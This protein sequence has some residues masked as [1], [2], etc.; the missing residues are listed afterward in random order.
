MAD[1]RPAAERLYKAMKG[2]GTDEATLID[3]AASHTAD[4]RLAIAEAFAGLYGDTL[5][6]WLKKELSGHLEKL[7]VQL[8]KGRYQ[9]WAQYLDD[10]VRGAGTDEKLLIEMIFLMSDQD[11]Q[12]VE[13]EYRKLFNKD[14]T[15]TIEGDI[16]IGHWAKLIRAWL[17]AKNDAPA[18][19]EK[20]ADDLWAAAK[21]AG[22]DEQVF[23]QVLANC[24]PDVYHQACDAF[25]RKYRKDVAEVI[26]REF[27][28]KSEKAFLA[29]HYSLFDKRQSIARNLYLSYKGAGTDE[30]RLIRQTVLF[31]DQLRGQQLVEAYKIFGDVVKDTKR[32]LSGKFEKAVLAVWGLS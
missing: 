27:S 23:M 15:K 2:L 28:G 16:S 8:F 32:D 14:L 19:P 25:L 29:A 11:Q 5:E 30:A 20:I 9:M 12:R 13:V 6:K 24:Q 26:K 31:S 18:N 10:A 22:T 3:V 7:M 17:H 4:E 21:G 1:Y